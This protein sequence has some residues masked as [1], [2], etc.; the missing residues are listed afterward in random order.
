LLAQSSDYWVDYV[1]GDDGTLCGAMDAITLMRFHQ[2][3]YTEINQA[4]SDSGWLEKKS[5]DG[6]Y[7]FPESTIASIDLQ[8]G[9]AHLVEVSRA[10][11]KYGNQIRLYM[12][13]PPS[14][15]GS[16]RLR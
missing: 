8:V 7:I 3:L 14:I 5:R 11:M 1:H 2:T 10:I 16:G 15:S 9:N 13:C 6:Q 12:Q 4:K